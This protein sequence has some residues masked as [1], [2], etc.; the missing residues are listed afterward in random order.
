M[1]YQNKTKE[2]LIKELRKLQQKNNSLKTSY[3]KDI[4]ERKQAE[5]ALLQEKENF[6]HS[7]D[8]SPLGVCIATNEGDTIYT[9]KTLLNLYGYDSLEE[10]QKTSLKDRYTPE[11]YAQAQ[12]R[13]YER[14]CGD[15][16]A[17]D[18]EI[19]IVRK[20]GEIRHL[21]VYR[22]EV[23]WDGVSQTQVIYKDIT[24]HKQAKAAQ[25]DS[26]A[27][28]RNLFENSL[29]GISVTDPDGHLVQINQSY[30]RM[31]GYKNPEEML[32]E[33]SNERQLYSNPGDRKEVLQLLRRNGFVGARMVEVVRRDG[34]R[35]PVLV[36]ANEIRDADGKLIYNQVTQLDITERRQTEEELRTSKELLEKLNQHHLE[37]RENER[38]VISREIHDQLGQS[39]TALKLDL[40]RMH[41]YLDNN[42]E[43]VKKLKGMIELVSDTIKDVQ[44]ISTDLRPGILDEL[45]L[46]ST[47]EW[48]C[49]EFEKRTGIKCNLKLDNS[50]YS[51]SQ[52]NLTFFRVLQETL[53]NVIRHAKA[54]SVSIKLH[55][56]KKGATMTVK[57]DGIG[58]PEEKIRSIK[59]LGLISMRERVKQFNGSI[60]ISSI[61]KYGTKL[62]IFIPS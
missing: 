54:S 24:V 50:D 48:Y 4:I 21:Q 9:N 46:V 35:F 25:R 17:T 2:V 14:K 32:A 23:L 57:D 38:A 45:G 51:N 10:L 60:D 13:K 26:E 52:I 41:M 19:S 29:M 47:I 20:N 42:P 3:E 61:K 28:F 6:R 53:T 59:S 56:L 36:S 44:R 40:N 30:A 34:S 12:K 8:D 49:D 15:L 33:V 11:S 7:L 22:K 62:V 16:N 39:M 27:R 18:Y 58:I 1:N 5:E 31:Y 43:A 55:R 37:V